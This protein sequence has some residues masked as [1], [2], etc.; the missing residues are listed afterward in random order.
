MQRKHTILVHTIFWVT[1]LFLVG[2]ETI[3]S[4][5]KITYDIIAADYFLYVIS[6]FALFYSFYFFIKKEHLNKKRIR[7][8]IIFGLLFVLFINVPIAYIYVLSLAKEVFNLNGNA[9]LLEFTKYYMSFLETNFLFAMSGSLMKIALLW[10]D[11]VMK[12]KEMEKQLIAG[13]LA[14][15]RSQINPQFLFNTLTIIKSL[16]E[17]QPEKAIYNIENLSEIMSYML[18]ETSANNVL[19][20]DEINNIN[21]Y[22]NLQR[23]RYSPDFIGFEVTG[24]TEGISVP[25][26]IFMP[27]IENAVK[28]AD[29]SS[30]NPG[31][32]IN[33]DVRKNNLSFE[34]TNHIKENADLSK[35]EDGFSIKSI[36]RRLDL[37]FG[38]KY[39]LEIKNENYKYLIKLNIELN[40]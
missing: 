24:D 32:I 19:L 28:Y 10:Y 5:G 37:I 25:P 2:L 1:M 9:F 40:A 36:K 11:N 20:K 34:V 15:L 18:Y 3:P 13:E 27:F 17:L 14:L 6:F 30:Q 16:I 26:L 29:G 33:L 23:V 7:A 4:M 31:I 39:N 12:Q 21:N 22:L 35:P 38:N 8:F